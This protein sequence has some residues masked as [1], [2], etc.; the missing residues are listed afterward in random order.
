MYRNSALLCI[1]CLPLVFPSLPLAMGDNWRG[2]CLAL[3]GQIHWTKTQGKQQ[4]DMKLGDP[5]GQ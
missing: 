4:G 2:F 1:R 5:R 3:C